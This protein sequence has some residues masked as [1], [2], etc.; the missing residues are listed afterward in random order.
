MIDAAYGLSQV[1]SRHEKPI[2]LVT[3]ESSEA[4]WFIEITRSQ[5]AVC[6]SPII[7][8][9]HTRARLALLEHTFP[10][11]LYIG[12]LDDTNLGQRP[13]LVLSHTITV[14]LVLGILQRQQA[15]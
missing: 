1:A 13:L 14:L 12:N 11:A 7:R 6:S 4:A 8:Q 3:A 10:F 15:R 9:S 2:A 5:G